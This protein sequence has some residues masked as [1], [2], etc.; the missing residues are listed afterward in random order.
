MKDSQL[1]FRLSEE[2]K[3]EIH[4]EAERL[5]I[6]TS[7]YLVHLHKRRMQRLAEKRRECEKRK[8]EIV[9]I[10]FFPYED[11]LKEEDLEAFNV[12]SM[13]IDQGLSTSQIADKLDKPIKAIRDLLIKSNSILR[14]LYDLEVAWRA[15]IK[16]ESEKKERLALPSDLSEKLNQVASTPNGSTNS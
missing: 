9:R 12:A 5:E 8:D 15:G 11:Y 6:S 7:D 3:I 10:E 16:F 4:G 14:N 13:L 1:M 2:D